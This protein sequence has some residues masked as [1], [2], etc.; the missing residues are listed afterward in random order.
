MIIR[1]AKKSDLKY[2]AEIGKIPE[3]AN[4]I[5][6]YFQPEYFKC[7]LNKNFFLVLE[8]D[9]KVIGFLIAEPIKAKGAILWYLTVEKSER[10]KGG[11]QKLIKE[12]EKRCKN[13]KITWIILYCP[14]K[15]S[16][17]ISF[18]KK[19]DYAEGIQLVEFEKYL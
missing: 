5:D 15:N 2:I 3:F 17:S 14:I 8:K 12:F 18:Y 9:K 16:K 19:L 1:P 7:Y 10:G 6:D 4:G 11:G 13:R